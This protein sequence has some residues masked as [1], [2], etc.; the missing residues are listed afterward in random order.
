MHPASK[1]PFYIIKGCKG[2]TKDKSIFFSLH[3]YWVM[4]N[5]RR[6]I[7]WRRRR[8]RR[9][10]R[11]RRGRASIL[12][13]YYSNIASGMLDRETERERQRERDTERE[14]QRKRETERQRK[15][16]TE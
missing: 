1:Q 7:S 15:R 13:F 5:S 8:R 6:W 2:V 16:E 14:R 3:A 12:S 11:K 10:T 4:V 9:R